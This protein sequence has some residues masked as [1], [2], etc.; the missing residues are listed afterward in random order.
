MKTNFH[1]LIS[2]RLER[3]WRTQMLTRWFAVAAAALL[4]SGATTW[5]SDPVGLYAIVDKVKFEPSEDK[6][7]RVVIWGTFSVADGDRGEKYRSP[8]KGYLY[9]ALPEKKAEVAQKEWADLKSVAGKNEV[10]GFSTRW[11]E[12]AKVRKES[13]QPKDPDTYRIGIGV[14]RMEKRGSDYPPV[15]ALLGATKQAPKQS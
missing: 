8:E 3:G 9:L 11:G 7:E 4:F 15:K 13:D 10:V 1:S 5:A 2:G 14:V 12:Q 6:P